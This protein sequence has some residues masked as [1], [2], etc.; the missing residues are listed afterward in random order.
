MI[1]SFAADSPAGLQGSL[2]RVYGEWRKAMLS[3]NYPAWKKVT[4]Y[5]RQ[6]ETRNVVTSKKKAFPKALFDLPMRPPATKGLRPLQVLTKGPTAVAIYYG[7]ADFGI[8]GRVPNSMMLLKFLKEGHQWKFY[9]LT[10]MNQ[11]PKEVHADIAANRLG[12]LKEAEFQPSGRA[13]KIQKPCPKPDYITDVHIISLGFDTKV[14]ING[15]SEHETYD[16][17]GT[18]LVIGGLRRGKN[19]VTVQAK[20][21]GKPASGRKDLKV[22]VHIKT[23]DL[24]NPAIQMLEFKPDPKKGPFTYSGTIIADPKKLA[25][26]VKW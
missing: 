12:F 14:T 11:L 2:E 17:Y 7:R 24:K 26:K 22:S 21:L 4:A 19:T 3:R 8:G 1:V 18:Q 16:D 23:G 15:I 13:P 6:I 9:T 10:L 5:A 20:P 25:G